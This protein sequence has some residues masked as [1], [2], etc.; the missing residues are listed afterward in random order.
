MV[1]NRLGAIV[2]LSPNAQL[3]KFIQRGIDLCTSNPRIEQRIWIRALFVAVLILVSSFAVATVIF[4]LG[5]KEDSQLVALIPRD[6]V[7][8]HKFSGLIG[9]LIVLLSSGVLCGGA[10]F[11][12]DIFGRSI[13][14]MES[15]K[16]EW[17]LC[18]LRRYLLGERFRSE[19][20]DEYIGRFGTDAGRQLMMLRES[21]S[22]SRQKQYS[23]ISS[24]PEAPKTSPRPELQRFSH[25]GDIDWSDYEGGHYRAER[26]THESPAY[27]GF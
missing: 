26:N 25:K 20:V 15:L 1:D 8:Y 4:V 23:P 10:F 13:D 3:D 6:P 7:P 9:L 16:H 14:A 2:K 24:V 21:L 5:L 17:N 22:P 19:V 11:A 12:F 27:E 18:E